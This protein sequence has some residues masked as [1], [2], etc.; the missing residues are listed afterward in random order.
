M[1]EVSDAMHKVLKQIRIR[2]N[3][4]LRIL[5]PIGLSCWLRALELSLLPVV[6]YLRLNYGRLQ[7]NTQIIHRRNV[8]SF[9]EDRI[10]YG[11][12]Y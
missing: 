6:H 12:S 4:V 1:Q 8:T 2:P 7:V 11:T 5:S 3:Q 9:T 10:D